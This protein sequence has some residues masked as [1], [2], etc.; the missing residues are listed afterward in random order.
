M[1]LGGVA[2]SGRILMRSL[3]LESSLLAAL[4]NLVLGLAIF[5]RRPA[6][7]VHQAFGLLS[8]AIALWNVGDFGYVLSLARDPAAPSPGWSRLTFAGSMAIPPAAFIL[9]R[10]L[11]RRGRDWTWSYGWA[12]LA[13]FALVLALLWS[14]LFPG[15]YRLVAA[16]YQFPNL[17]LSLA[18]LLVRMRSAGPEERLQIK[19]V[20]TGGLLATAFGVTDYLAAGGVAPVPR[21]G[22]P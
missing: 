19:Y 16:A 10:G 5:L 2:R 17:G 6:S 14:P 13:Q 8:L 9:V 22:A 21:L 20:F 15:N 3:E 7:R 12:L 1:R 4:G 11:T 18:L